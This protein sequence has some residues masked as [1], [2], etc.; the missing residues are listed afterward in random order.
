MGLLLVVFLILVV[1]S[2]SWE[3]IG[4]AAS[5]GAANNATQH[6]ILKAMHWLNSTTPSNSQVVSVTNFDF[7]FY[8]LL[9][10]R[11]SG[12]VPLAAPDDVVNAAFGSTVPTYVVL[13]DRRN[14]HDC[15]SQATNPFALYP[16]DTRFQLQYNDCGVLIYELAR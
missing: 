16:N 9:Y 1:N 10:G 12:Y 8:Q 13:T 11:P 7:T 15:R 3:V 4:D 6:G 14:R 5:N 2:W